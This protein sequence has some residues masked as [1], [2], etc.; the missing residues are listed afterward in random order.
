MS[1]LIGGLLDELALPIG[2]NLVAFLP[3]LYSVQPSAVSLT[4]ILNIWWILDTGRGADGL[5]LDKRGAGEMGCIRA[6]EQHS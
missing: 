2:G 6:H 5:I 3:G 1:W 4:M